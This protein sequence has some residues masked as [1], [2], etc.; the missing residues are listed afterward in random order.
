MLCM[1]SGVSTSI[2]SDMLTA[3]YTC[4]PDKTFSAV[5]INA[6]NGQSYAVITEADALVPLRSVPSGSGVT[7]EDARPDSSLQLRT[8]GLDAWLHDETTKS[9]PVH[10]TT[11]AFN[12]D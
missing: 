6:E 1:A 8:K 3:D 9:T 4:G 11:E 7:Y 10:C 12:Q 2:A 5:F